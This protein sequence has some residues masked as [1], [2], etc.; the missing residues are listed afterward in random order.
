MAA[1]IEFKPKEVDPRRELQRR[2]ESAPLEHAESILAVLDL[3]EAAHQQG[4]LGL[5]EGAISSKDAVFAKLA[6]YAKQPE[7]TTALRNV[8][9]IGKLVGSIPAEKLESIVKNS[10]G[11]KQRPPSLFRL[12]V[13]FGSQD[14]RSGLSVALEFLS[15]LGS[16]RR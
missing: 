5:A 2:L 12:L 10:S 6:E 15:V 11:S 14:V 16:A 8:L 9:A 13:R 3:L 7:C 4:L 1:P